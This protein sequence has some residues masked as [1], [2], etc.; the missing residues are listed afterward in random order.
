MNK[1]YLLITA[2]IFG[3]YSCS[4]EKTFCDDCEYAKQ[5]N[6]LIYNYHESLPHDVLKS[7]VAKVE[8]L[9][10][11]PG[12]HQ[13]DVILSESLFA[14]GIEN[15]R[16]FAYYI[17]ENLADNYDFVFELHGNGDFEKG[18]DYFIGNESWLYEFY[19]DK[20]TIVVAPLGSVKKNA[21]ATDTYGWYVDNGDL[22]YIDFLIVCFNTKIKEQKKFNLNLKGIFSTGQSSG[23]IFSWQLGF[24]RDN[25]FSSVVP[26]F[27]MVKLGTE[28]KF[29]N[30]EYKTPMR[31]LLGEYDPNVMLEAALNNAEIWAKEMN[32]IKEDP[33]PSMTEWCYR[34]SAKISKRKYVKVL[35]TTYQNEETIVETYVLKMATHQHGNLWIDYQEFVYDFFMNNRKK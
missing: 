32:G 27:G 12:Y 35:I 20:N 5:N 11:T 34:Y 29:K 22:N 7:E 33:I 9:D 16:T 6:K 15:K 21:V 3:L 18:V 28:M 8:D 31:V 26:R 1:L 30:R 23:A 25:V 10:L 4:D 14:D 24:Y 2:A 17:P 13:I 19:A